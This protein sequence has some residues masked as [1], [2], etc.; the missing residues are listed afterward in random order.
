MA[1]EEA[2]L[3]ENGFMETQTEVQEVTGSNQD[4]CQ[5]KVEVL[6]FF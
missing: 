6:F 5:S 3:V 2:F 1:I 4:E